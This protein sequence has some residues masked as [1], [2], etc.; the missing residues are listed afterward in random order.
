MTERK[1]T[2]FPPHCRVASHPKE[3]EEG[4]REA[5][6]SGGGHLKRV[7]DEYVELGFECLLV[8]LRPDEVEGCTRCYKSGGEPLYRV[9][10]RPRGD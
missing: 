1:E 9:Y 8:E 2:R 3:A 4:W 10:V 7:L 6:I 5:L